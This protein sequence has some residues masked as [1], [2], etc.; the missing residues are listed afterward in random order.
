MTADMN[1]YWVATDKAL[2]PDLS[3][4]SAAWSRGE[5]CGNRLRMLNGAF[6][7]YYLL[8]TSIYRCT[9]SALRT[10]MLGELDDAGSKGWGLGVQDMDDAFQHWLKPGNWT[11]N[12]TD[13][14]FQAHGVFGAQVPS[15]AGAKFCWGLPT[16]LMTGPAA[17]VHFFESLDKRLKKLSDAIGSH[18]SE[19][20][21]LRKAI[22][23]KNGKGTGEA[24]HKIADIAKV[25]KLFLFLAPKPNDSF[26]T[27]VF[28]GG[29]GSVSGGTLS[30]PLNRFTDL[31]TPSPFSG[32]PKP[33]DSQPSVGPAGAT[34]II[35][36]TQT[37]IDLD[38][39]LRVHEGSLRTGI[40]DN[41]TSTEFA[42]LAVALGKVPILGS[43]YAQMVR[44]L[45]GFFIGMRD[46]FEEH[47]RNIDRMTRV[48]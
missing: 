8:R 19:V 13:D 5:Y 28:T 6:E 29:T 36:F 4:V 43:F 23:T 20:V 34:A 41:R 1:R 39:F 26:L 2:I 24:L 21:N 17:A 14:Y 48:N 32:K 18:N 38:T 37:V 30:D 12:N 31:N 33:A 11:D 27:D 46:M 47:Y 42:F 45:P 40:F 15:I 44:S 7:I 10:A 35:S 25:A 22:E 3:S 9:D 16:N